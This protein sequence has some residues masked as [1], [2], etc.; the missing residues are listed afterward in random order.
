M[1]VVPYQYDITVAGD[2][3]FLCGHVL[4]D[5]VAIWWH[6]H[7]NDEHG[8]RITLH[9]DCCMNLCIFLMSDLHAIK[10]RLMIDSRDTG[11][12]PPSGGE[13]LFM[14]GAQRA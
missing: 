8:T 1:G 3:C 5:N 14:L 4:R 12:M 10:N 7:G 2:T 13:I 9:P 6:G 11:A